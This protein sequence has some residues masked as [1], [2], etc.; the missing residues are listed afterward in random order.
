MRVQV[1]V[2][3]LTTEGD[4][5]PVNTECFA[6]QRRAILQLRKYLLPESKGI[7][8]DDD[9]VALWE[10]TNDGPACI[11]SHEV[12]FDTDED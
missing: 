6:T 2:W 8:N 10:R 3:T 9:L 5:N 11:E 1:T 12:T 4:N 7:T